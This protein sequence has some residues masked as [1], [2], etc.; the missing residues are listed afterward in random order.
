MLR[1]KKNQWSQKEEKNVLSRKK[2]TKKLKSNVSLY[3]S[4]TTIK[5]HMLKNWKKNLVQVTKGILCCSS[6]K[7]QKKS[8]Q[9]NFTKRKIAE[10]KKNC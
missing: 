10:A 3:N 5:M 2:E 6:G 8:E 9:K 7:N 4:E 1:S